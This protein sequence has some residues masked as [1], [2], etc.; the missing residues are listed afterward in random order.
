MHYA[1]KQLSLATEYQAKGMKTN[2][3]ITCV[4]IV[5]LIFLLGSFFSWSKGGKPDWQKKHEEMEKKK[6]E[7]AQAKAKEA[8]QTYASPV[9]EHDSLFLQELSQD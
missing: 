8:Q 2:A 1:E 4:L 5:I 3:G 7:A 9:E 6:L